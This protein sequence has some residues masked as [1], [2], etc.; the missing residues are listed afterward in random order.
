MARDKGADML[1]DAVSEV[2]PTFEVKTAGRSV[3]F[4]DGVG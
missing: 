4:W 1:V 2:P 3:I